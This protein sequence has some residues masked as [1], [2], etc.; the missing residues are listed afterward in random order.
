MEP[1]PQETDPAIRSGRTAVLTGLYG[2]I[3]LSWAYLIYRDWV[4]RHMDIVGMAM[5][6]M[7]PWQEAELLSVFAMWGIMMVAMMLPAAMPMIMFFAMANRR[8]QAPQAPVV[9]TWVFVSGYLIVWIGFSAL[10]TVGQWSLQTASMLSPTMLKTTPLIGG[11]L[12]IIAGIYQWTPLKRACLVHCRTPLGFIMNHW[13]DGR[14]GAFLMGLRHGLYCLGCCWSL[15]T[16]LFVTGVMNL[17]WIAALSVFVIL[18][19]TSAGGLWIA[20]GA[21]LLFLS[22]GSWLLFVNGWF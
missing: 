5:P 22:W 15:M 11:F 4:M 16:L 19:K 21:G 12:L 20:R 1:S 8:R 6:G 14:K 18:E 13:R 9:R 3:A 7:H 2:M 17:I 10:A